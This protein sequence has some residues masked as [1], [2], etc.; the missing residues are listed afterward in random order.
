MTTTTTADADADADARSSS[1]SCRSSSGATAEVGSINVQGSY[2]PPPHFASHR[3]SPFFNAAFPRPRDGAA[4]SL[5]AAAAYDPARERED[6]NDDEDD[7]AWGGRG[8][9]AI[10]RGRTIA[11]TATSFGLTF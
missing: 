2:L 8:I 3:P 6:Y 9:V 1:K 4:A 10:I 11:E 7:Y 5:C